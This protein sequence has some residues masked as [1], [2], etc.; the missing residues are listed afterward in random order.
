MCQP[1][2]GLENNAISEC[3]VANTLIKEPAEAQNDRRGEDRN[4]SGSLAYTFSKTG[5]ISSLEQQQSKG[6]ETL[7][8]ESG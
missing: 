2:T 4:L 6:L 5:N 8:K 7:L 1:I 3:N